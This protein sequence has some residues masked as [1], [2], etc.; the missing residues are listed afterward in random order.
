MDRV[1]AGLRQ[2]PPDSPRKCVTPPLQFDVLKCAIFTLSAGVIEGCCPLCSNLITANPGQAENSLIV[3]FELAK[4]AV[5]RSTQIA[6][7]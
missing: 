1:S 7:R 2:F 6:I 5:F 3:L 4:P